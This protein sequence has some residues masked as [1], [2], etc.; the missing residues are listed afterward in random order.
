MLEDAEAELG[1]GGN[2][3]VEDVGL[4]G[5]VPGPGLIVTEYINLQGQSFGS[6]FELADQKGH[7][8]MDLRILLEVGDDIG[9]KQSCIGLA[10]A[11][12]DL[13]SVNSVFPVELL[14]LLLPVAD[15]VGQEFYL[16][17]I[18]QLGIV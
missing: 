10:A 1:Q 17:H 7:I 13:R 6:G 8:L 16:C 15:V 14:D 2:Q 18:F 4:D 5:L 9:S 12:D 3:V 11:V